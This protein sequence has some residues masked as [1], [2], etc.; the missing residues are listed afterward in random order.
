ML[1]GVKR[2]KPWPPRDLPNRPER[3]AALADVIRPGLTLAGSL[4]CPAPVDRTLPD[5]L[6]ADRLPDHVAL[7][8]RRRRGWPRGV[9]PCVGFAAEGSGGVVEALVLRG[10]RRRWPSLAGS[11]A[12]L[13]TGTQLAPCP[14]RDSFC[15]RVLPLNSCGTGPVP[16][17]FRAA[18]RR[19]RFG[20]NVWSFVPQRRA[21]G[22]TRAGTAIGEQAGAL[23]S[24]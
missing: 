20:G 23:T 9:R 2:W 10:V 7:S 13:E 16:L 21:S 24:R 11:F 4:C 1:G 19:L 17:L 18:N 8:R 15:H 12:P 6:L 14:E 22:S 3:A 5:F